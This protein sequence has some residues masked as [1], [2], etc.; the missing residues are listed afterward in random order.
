M[1]S[2]RSLIFLLLLATLSFVPSSV[3]AQDLDNVT[4]RGKV[5]DQNG[6]VIPGASI[7]ATL[8][9]TKAERTVVADAD[10]NYKLIQLPPGVYNVKASFTNFATEEKTDL[11][12]IAAQNVQL[13]FVLK[14]ASVTAEAIVVSAADTAQVDTT[15]TIVG[16][17]VATR[18]VEALPNSTR[19]P[20]DLIFTLGG[21]SEEALSTRDLSEDRAATRSTPEEAGTFSISGA[22]AYS[23]NITIDGLDNNDDRAARERF[24]PSLEA[25][26]EVQLIRNQFAAEYGRASG[27]RLNLRTRG[28]ASKFHGRGFYFFRD[29]A[30]DAN[31]WKNNSLGLKRLPLQEH[32][33]GFTLSGP[34]IIPKLYKGQRRTFFFSAYEYDTLLDSSLVNTLLP[35]QQNGLFALPAPTDPANQRIEAASAPALS[36]AVAPFVTLINTPSRNHI[37]TTRVDHKFTNMHNGQVLYQMGRFTNLRQFGGGNRLAEALLG[38]T[39][40]SDAIAYLD[41]YVLSAK[42]VAETRFQFSR[43]TPAVEANGGAASPVVLIGIND[44]LKLVTGTLVA[45]S[46]TSGATDRRESRF[47][48]QEVFSYISGNHSLKVGGDLQKIKSTFIDLEDASG[49]WDFDSAGDFLANTPS[50]FRQDFLT[51]S[52]QRNTYIGV[53]VQD[54][55]RIKPNFMLSYGVRYENESIVH[56]VNNFGPRVAIA[57]DP[58]KTGKTVIRAGAGI[59]YNRALLRTIDDFTLGAQQRFFDTNT[60]VDPATGKLMSSAQ[61]RAFIAANLRFPQTLTADSSLVRQFGVLNSGFSR[62]LDPSL[63]I[64]ESYQTNIGV[65]RQIGRRLVF[66]ANYTWNRGLH[67]WREFNVNAPRLPNGFKNFTDYLAS[68]DFTNFLSAPGGVRP[69][70]NTTTAGDLVRF[71][72]AP[73]DP[74]NPNSVVRVVEFGVPASLINLNAFTSTTSVDTALAAL[75]SL[76]PDPSKGEV[77]QLIPVGNSQYHGLTLEL[78]HRF[79]SAKNGAGFSFRAVYTLSFLKDDG[80]VNT[81]DALVAGD[82]QREF[83]RSLLDR[84]HRFAFSGTFDLPRVLGKFRLSSVLRLASGAPFNI[85]LGGADRN[86]DDVGNDRPIF[87]GNINA[88]RWRSPGEPFDVSILNQFTLPTIGQTGNLPRNAGLGPGQFLLDLNVT[89]EFKLSERLRLRPTV[90]FNNVLNAAVFAFGSEFIDFS[91]FGPTST[92]A[93]RQ[94]FIDSFLV[95]TRTLRPRQIRLGVRVDF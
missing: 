93:A 69:L 70:L 39:R 37:F 36:A 62:R 31:T 20:I 52:T 89:R 7:T 21:V 30:L 61:R 59:F 90:E 71:V 46:S 76:R 17:T 81:S 28:G 75:N 38:K 88:L 58:F 6:A 12:T 32:D 66:E 41:N 74:A 95:P 68:R 26:A 80:I 11:N 45:G 54:E 10:G 33:P 72:L 9:A 64:P 19:S 84:R 73:P 94:A 63:N 8:V 42:A 5:T 44:P 22:P 34:V 92:P 47:Q 15:R 25:V 16:G 67:L 49:T 13:N 4:I 85:G 77:E 83:T 43:L 57:Y 87:T 60:L 91:A 48:F 27:G 23:N 2:S 18:E 14:P 56:D 24:T 51:T 79:V 40:N 78:R 55:W 35:V 86:L 3:A 53:F 65:E 1:R 82:F 50:R 29:E